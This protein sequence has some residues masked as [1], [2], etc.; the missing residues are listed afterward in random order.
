MRDVGNLGTLDWFV[1]SLS[2]SLQGGG[3]GGGF[4]P[5]LEWNGWQETNQVFITAMEYGGNSI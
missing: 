3:G 2:S 1:L 4:Q 5:K